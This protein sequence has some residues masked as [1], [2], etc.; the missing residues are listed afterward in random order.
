MHVK[1]W[2]VDDEIVLTGSTNLTHGGLENNKEHLFRITEPSVVTAVVDDFE[3]LWEQAEEV[4]PAMIARMVATYEKE[5]AA[6]EAEKAAKRN[7]LS[8][9]MLGD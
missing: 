1:T 7:P 4:T 3:L 8:E 5:K 6:K 9:D 2:I